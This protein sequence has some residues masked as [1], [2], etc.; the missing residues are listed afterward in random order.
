MT[1]D[2]PTLDQRRAR[3]AWEAVER[4]KNAGGKMAGDYAR[5][6]KRLPVRIVTAGLGHAIAFLR[7]KGDPGGGDANATLLS[8]LADWVLD[9]RRDVASRRPTPSSAALIEAI[10]KGDATFLQVSTDEALAY[11]QWLGRFA[12]AELKPS[13]E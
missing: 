3:H 7:A 8:D 13:E 1:A 11:L 2:A 9:K 4:I 10:V 12:E 5:E 6:V